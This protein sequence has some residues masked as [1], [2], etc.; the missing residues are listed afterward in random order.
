MCNEISKND[1]RYKSI[2]MFP[3]YLAHG[4]G[5]NWCGHKIN[6]MLLI[7]LWCQNRIKLLVNM[8]HVVLVTHIARGIIR[9]SGSKY[10]NYLQPDIPFISKSICDV[11][12]NKSADFLIWF[13]NSTNL[14]YFITIFCAEFE[15]DPASEFPFWVI[16]TH[17]PDIL[18]VA[19]TWNHYIPWTFS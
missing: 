5:K 2:I 17:T 8:G 19:L 11:K 14:V 7:I 6:S 18:C 12:L 13:E 10:P 3:Q 9:M 16:I 1:V 4:R 15:N